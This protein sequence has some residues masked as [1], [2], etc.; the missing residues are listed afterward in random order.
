MVI[1]FSL[2]VWI[3]CYYLRLKQLLGLSCVPCCVVLYSA[4]LCCDVLITCVVLGF[5]RSFTPLGRGSSL[6]QVVGACIILLGAWVVLLPSSSSSSSS[7][8]SSTDSGLVF[9]SNML[10]MASNI[11]IALR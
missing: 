5:I 7:T 8:D 3:I 10:Y 2:L 11:P 4:V 6:Y 9:V 1:C